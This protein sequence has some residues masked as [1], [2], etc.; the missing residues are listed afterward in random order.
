MNGA[1]RFRYW[2]KRMLCW[3]LV[4]IAGGPL[5]GSWI[6]LFTGSRFIKGS[7]GPD[8]AAHFQ[9]LVK[10]GDVVFD[11]GAHVGYFTML[12]AHIVG[13]SGKVFAFEPLPVNLAYLKQH[14][15]VNRLKNVEILP[16]AVGARQEEMTLDLRGG[17]GR[18]RLATGRADGLQVKVTSLDAM[19]DQGNLPGPDFIKMD[20]EGAEC[21]ALRG[22]SR[23]LARYRPVI[24]LSLH[25]E[26]G[27]ESK[28]ILA[29]L[30]YRLSQVDKSIIVA[31]PPS[32]VDAAESRAAD[33]STSIARAA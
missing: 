1:T 25:G 20:I 8:E 32:A 19:F 14:Q 27:H 17:T 24:L 2:L 3:V 23:L 9:Q 4:P 26:A 12:A 15:R 13:T 28:S 10:P 21:D 33:Q 31:L 6:G 22:A 18:G 11:I 30:G 16:L 5:K 7:Y 29:R